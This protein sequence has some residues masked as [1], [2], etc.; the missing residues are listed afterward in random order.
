MATAAAAR[1]AARPRPPA[2]PE[3]ALPRRRR[4]AF[5]SRGDSFSP[6]LIR[7][8]RVARVD[9]PLPWRGL[10]GGEVVVV[11]AG[12]GLERNEGGVLGREDLGA[13]GGDHVGLGGGAA[14]GA[15]ADR[16]AVL[17]VGELDR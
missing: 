11:A 6:R 1:I 14:D 10:A 15:P 12:E 17:P 4:G 2:R 9:A 7:P 5:L 3:R 16:R 8:A 13:G